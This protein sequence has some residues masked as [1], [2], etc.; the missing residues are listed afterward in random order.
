[1]RANILTT[2]LTC[3]FSSALAAAA[4][5]DLPPRTT[6]VAGTAGCGTTHWFNGI[7][8]YHSLKSSGRD[9]SYSIHLPNDYD[10]NKPYPLV[11]GFHG[12]DGIGLFFEL[13]TRMSSSDYSANVSDLR[14]IEE[15]G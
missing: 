14:W 10:E 2:A 13:D 11:L 1:M 9:R 4:A 12:S 5:L 8:Q 3:L 15:S 7:T 6:E